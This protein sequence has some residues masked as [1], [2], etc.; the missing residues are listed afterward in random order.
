M[1]EFNLK[2]QHLNYV[3]FGREIT[4][5]HNNSKKERLFN[6]I[7]TPK[8]FIN[9]DYDTLIEMKCALKCFKPVDENIKSELKSRLELIQIAIDNIFHQHSKQ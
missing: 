3:D 9:L 4:I 6:K 7:L 5:N 2:Y 1:N 8:N